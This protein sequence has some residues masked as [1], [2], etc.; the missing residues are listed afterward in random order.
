MNKSTHLIAIL[1][2]DLTQASDAVRLLPAGSFRARDG[3]PE[4]AEHWVITQETAQTVIADFEA[5]KTDFLIDF[6]HQTIHTE[7][8]GQPAPAAGW[9]KRLTWRDDGLWLEE[10]EWTPEARK[11]I[12]NGAY[13]YLSPVMNYLPGSGIVQ[14][15]L[16]AAVTNNPALDGLGELQNRVAARYQNNHP[17][18]KPDNPMDKETQQ[19]LCQA[20]GLENDADDAAI[21]TALTEMKT[22]TES[23]ES[24]VASL[25]SGPDTQE[26]S[27]TPAPAAPDPAQ[28]APVAALKATQD[29]LTALKQ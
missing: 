5:S 13:R 4:D 9:G 14:R 20:L 15:V 17:Q 24:Q 22:R 27:N 16:H 6:E 7:W 28:F 12:E 19:A 29:E 3:R 8:N 23:L 21:S 18:P 25:T 2:F 1:S 11:M 26:A 10:V